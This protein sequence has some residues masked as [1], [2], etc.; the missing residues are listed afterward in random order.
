MIEIYAFDDSDRLP[1]DPTPE[2]IKAACARIQA[3]WSERERVRRMAGVGAVT[4]A[5]PGTG[6]GRVGSNRPAD[7]FADMAA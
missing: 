4:W 5:V 3:G 7:D 6:G 2:Q 1:H